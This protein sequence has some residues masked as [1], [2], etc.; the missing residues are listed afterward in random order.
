MNPLINIKQKNFPTVMEISQEIE[1]IHALLKLNIN[2]IL[3]E[4]M[5][6]W[7]YYQICRYHMKII[8]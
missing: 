3:E 1:I 7:K 8:M 2:E 4:K 5:Y 6:L